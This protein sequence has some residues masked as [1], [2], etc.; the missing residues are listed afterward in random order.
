M[1]NGIGERQN[2]ENNIAYLAAQR[3]LYRD[4]K[5]W[6]RAIC[7]CSVILPFALSVLQ[8]FIT[9]V[10]TYLY[11]LSITSWA[12][13]GLIKGRLRKKKRTAAY[14][15]QNLIQMSIRCRGINIC[16]RRTGMFQGL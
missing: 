1:S 15:Q 13:S 8:I 5:N 3:Q 12:V 11:I 14:I 7:V 2:E 6:N 9:H 10:H 16:L 4:A